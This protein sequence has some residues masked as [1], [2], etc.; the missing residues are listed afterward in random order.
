MALRD[1]ANSYNTSVGAISLNATVN[2]QFNTAIGFQ[3][4]S[5]Y[6]HGNN[7]IFV[8]ANANASVAGLSNLIAVGWGTVVTSS[9]TARFG[10]SATVSYGGW[11]GWSN[12]SDGRFKKDIEENVPGLD[13]IN[14]LRPVTYHLDATELDAF[15]HKND[16]SAM[17]VSVKQ[18]HSIALSEKEKIRYT[19]FIAQEVEAVAKAL[20]FDF[21]GVDP[22]KNENDTYGLRYAEFV[23]PLVKAVQE[24]QQMIERLQKRNEELEKLNTAQKK[25]NDELFRRVEK[26]ELLIVDKK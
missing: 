2:S 16:T 25:L 26:L 15:L 9:N 11:A 4:G 17:S 1:N 10:N 21:S 7:N 6:N 23:V 24:Q 14:K 13:F 5:S 22:A 18:L 3:A 12:V 19:G 8:G 20:G